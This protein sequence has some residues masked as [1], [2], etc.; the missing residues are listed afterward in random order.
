MEM[1]FALIVAKILWWTVCQHAK[2]FH[3]NH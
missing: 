1:N 3:T 2:S